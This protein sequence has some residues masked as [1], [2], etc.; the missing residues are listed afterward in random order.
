MSTLVFPPA[1]CV[2]PG[3][4]RFTHGTVGSRAVPLCGLESREW[5]CSQLFE[6]PELAFITRHFGRA[7]KVSAC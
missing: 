3:R 2:W 5:A 6:L 7:A 4:A 1:A